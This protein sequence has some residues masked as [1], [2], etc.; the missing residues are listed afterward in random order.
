MQKAANRMLT[1][2]PKPY[3]Q[4]PVI[5]RRTECPECG[6]TRRRTNRTETLTGGNK[7]RYVSCCDC[8][9]RYK[10]YEAR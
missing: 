3:R 10:T 8:P 2:T 4:H 9:C 1:P 7:L 5:E 6:S